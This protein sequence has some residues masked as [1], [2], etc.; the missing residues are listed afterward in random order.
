MGAI[1]LMVIVLAHFFLADEPL[2][3]MKSLGFAVGFIGLMIVLGPETILAFDINAAD[4]KGELA[5]L[6]GCLCYAVHGIFARRIP[7]HQP[8]VQSAVV[9]AAGGILGTGFALLVAPANLSTMPV[10][11]FLS[12]LGL[13]IVPTAIATLLVYRIVRM[14]GVSFV[15]YSNYLVPV[16]ALGFGALMLGETLDWNVAIGLVLIFVGIAASHLSLGKTKAMT[17]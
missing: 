10:L 13:G 3:V 6:L 9:C 1:P 2:T 15:A 16:Y 12:V 7:F 4:L 8:I 11:A 5:I 17:S 14:V